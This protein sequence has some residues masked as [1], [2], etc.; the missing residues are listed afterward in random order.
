M[1]NTEPVVIF[2]DAVKTLGVHN[3]IVRISLI[4]LNP[5]GQAIPAAELMFPT[6]QLKHL[7]RALQ[8]IKT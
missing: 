3:G 7:V 4:R 8:Q 5:E 6:D 1:A 2:C